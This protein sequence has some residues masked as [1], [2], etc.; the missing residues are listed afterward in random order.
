M[1]NAYFDTDKV[2]ESER[3]VV[4][5]NKVICYSHLAP[6]SHGESQLIGAVRS[7]FFDNSRSLAPNL[8]SCAASREDS[9][10]CNEALQLH[11]DAVRK[12][13]PGSKNPWVIPAK[14][15]KAEIEQRA[16]AIHHSS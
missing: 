11:A 5:L 14:K 13:T 10:T 16:F 9:Y 8:P 4:L 2:R 6:F 3:V 7:Q 1:R 15:F 12:T